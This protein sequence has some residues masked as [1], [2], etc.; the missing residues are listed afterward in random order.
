MFDLDH[1]YSVNTTYMFQY[2]GDYQ[3][4]EE[5]LALDELLETIRKNRSRIGV[6]SSLAVVKKDIQKLYVQNL[7]ALKPLQQ[8][9]R[10]TDKK[11]GEIMYHLSGLTEKKREI[12]EERE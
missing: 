11:T 7:D 12:V 2:M 10:F 5:P 1:I 3:K 8:A 9:L 6:D 4:E